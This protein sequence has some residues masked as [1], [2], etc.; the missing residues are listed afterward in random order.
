MFTNKQNSYRMAAPIPPIPPAPPAALLHQQGVIAC[1]TTCGLT[2]PGQRQGWID[3][4]MATM[5]DICAFRPEEVYEVGAGLQKLP[6]GR[7]G[8]RQG[9]GDPCE[10]LKPLSDGALNANRLA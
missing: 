10:R 7:G 5:A 6:V 2:T 4:G 8:S 1:L 3:E 9:A